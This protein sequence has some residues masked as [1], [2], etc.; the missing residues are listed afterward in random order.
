M[1]MQTLRPSSARRWKWKTFSCPLRFGK[2]CRRSPRAKVVARFGKP[3]F[4][5]FSLC[6]ACGMGRN[7][8]FMLRGLRISFANLFR[9]LSAAS[10]FCVFMTQKQARNQ[11]FTGRNSFKKSAISCVFSSDLFLVGKYANLSPSEKCSICRILGDKLFRISY[12]GVLAFYGRPSLGCLN[13]LS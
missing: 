6:T 12:F 13:G 1:P 4:G 7:F 5:G 11:R 2:C 10:V 3:L 8:L 9:W